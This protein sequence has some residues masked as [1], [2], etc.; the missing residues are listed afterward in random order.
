MKKSN[1]RQASSLIE[2]L[3]VIAIIAVIVMIVLPAVQSVRAAAAATQCRNNLRQIGLALHSFHDTEGRL[4]PGLGV[5]PSRNSYPYLGWPARLLPWVDST[6]LWGQLQAAFASDPDPLKFYGYP[7]HQVLLGTPV[8]LYACPADARLPGPNL[9]S[10]IALAH[11]SYLGVHGVDQASHDGSLFP[12]SRIRFGDITDGQSQTVVV[13]ERP[14]SQDLKLGWWYRGWGQAKDGSAEM[15]LGARETNVSLPQCGPGPYHFTP[16]K[17]T[18]PCDAFHFWSPHS[19]G[20][21]FVFADGSVRF[22]AYSADA[23]I[24]ALTTRAGGEVF[25]TP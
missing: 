13:G 10:G 22:L 15:L 8:K 4:P 14:P 23:V 20:A 21:H 11:T 2:A 18:E 16:G 9:I 19:G 25:D 12:A 7:P 1:N 6:A 17:L 5:G 24:P 3:V